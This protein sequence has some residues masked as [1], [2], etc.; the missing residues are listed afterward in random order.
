MSSRCDTQRFLNWLGGVLQEAKLV[1]V[2]VVV[3]A[4]NQV[5]SSVRITLH[6]LPGQ[7]A[8]FELRPTG[9]APRPSEQWSPH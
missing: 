4:E 3:D 2:D 8:G 6:D 7:L 5:R 9:D 1:E